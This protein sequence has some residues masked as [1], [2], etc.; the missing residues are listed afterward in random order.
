[1]SGKSQCTCAD[2]E[3]CVP[4]RGQSHRG[5]ACAR[6]GGCVQVGTLKPGADIRGS[7]RVTVWPLGLRVLSSS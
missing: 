5:D 4:L 7:G 6:P 3:D 1:M 2:V